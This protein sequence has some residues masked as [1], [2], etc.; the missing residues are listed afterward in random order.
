MN[1]AVV[2]FLEEVHEKVETLN[3]LHEERA[4]D[5]EVVLSNDNIIFSIRYNW[6]EK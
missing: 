4:V 1:P 6:D 2:R 5:L 3:T